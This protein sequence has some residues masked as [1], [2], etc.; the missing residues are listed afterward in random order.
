MQELDAYLLGLYRLAREKQAQDFPAA[1][2]LGLRRNLR[3]ESVFWGNARQPEGPSGRLVPTALNVDGIDP[4]FLA[5][6]ARDCPDDPIMPLLQRSCGNTLEVRVSSFYSQTP[7]LSELGRRHRIQSYLV[8]ST[9]GLASGDLQWMSLFRPDPDASARPEE[10]VWFATVM[11]HLSE[12]WRI[13]QLLYA[14]DAPQLLSG[15]GWMAAVAGR[16]DGKLIKID[17]Q[18]PSTLAR[19]WSG[20]DAWCAPRVLRRAWKDSPAGFSYQGK[21]LWCKGRCAGDLVYLL[22][23]AVNGQTR[24]TPKQWQIARDWADGL[25]YKEIARHHALAANTVRK[26]LADIYAA[27]DVHS[28]SALSA[29]LEAQP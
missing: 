14:P 8:S 15:N 17:P 9:P 16:Q 27:L 3:F 6:W 5:A 2:A 12:A 28:R 11:P 1:V 29:W 7:D 20:F 10:R 13:N 18:L 25:S 21:T 23:R 22:I 19:E 4:G 24:L 26:H